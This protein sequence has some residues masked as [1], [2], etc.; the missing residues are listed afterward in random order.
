MKLNFFEIKD[1][2]F[3]ALVSKARNIANWGT[4]NKYKQKELRDFAFNIKDPM[5]EAEIRFIY[6]LENPHNVKNI[7]CQENFDP[8]NFTM[9][10]PT[11]LISVTNTGAKI[12]LDLRKLNE[13]GG[14]GKF[15]CDHTARI[16]NS[17][18]QA[19]LIP[20]L[21]LTGFIHV[22]EFPDF[23]QFSGVLG[24][25]IAGICK[26]Y[27]RENS[28]RVMLTGF[29]RFK[30]VKDNP[31]ARFLFGDGIS[32]EISSYGFFEPSGEAIGRL[33]KMIKNQFG[34]PTSA[35]TLVENNLKIGRTYTLPGNKNLDLVLV[36]LPVDTNIKR[37]RTSPAGCHNVTGSKTYPEFLNALKDNLFGDR[38]QHILY[39]TACLTKPQ[40]IISLGAHALLPSDFYEIET[41]VYGLDPK[42]SKGIRPHYP[43]NTGKGTNLELADIYK[44]ILSL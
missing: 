9:D 43:G 36:R 40:A 39:Y 18:K 24:L 10:L 15:I 13:A 17:F 44:N 34:E 38:I 42:Y 26:Q 3:L 33:D 6:S 32:N 4:L 7:L 25:G 30:R 12:T 22:P 19:F 5:S 27:C 2:D 28:I 35:E 16:I 23:S 31:T 8:F 29:T 37:Q 14:I 20:S 1:P 21:E 11:T 41:E